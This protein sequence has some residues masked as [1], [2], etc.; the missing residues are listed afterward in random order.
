M[1]NRQVR[2]AG[3]HAAAQGRGD[4]FHRLTAT[5]TVRELT[6]SL[7]GALTLSPTDAV[8]GA[9]AIL[10]E[11]GS[12]AAPVVSEGVVVGVFR[13]SELQPEPDRTVGEAMVRLSNA[14]W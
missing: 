14:R 5:I 4:L 6:T 10:V 8:S 12:D 3:D 13:G 2:R 9:D 7:A 11:P 1:H